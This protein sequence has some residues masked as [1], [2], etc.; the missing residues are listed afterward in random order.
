MLTGKGNHSGPH[1][2]QLG[3]TTFEQ[4]IDATVP[5]PERRK[6]ACRLQP[7]LLFTSKSI[8]QG[9]L[10]STPPSAPALHAV[11]ALAKLNTYAKGLA[12]SNRYGPDKGGQDCHRISRT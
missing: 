1:E 5:K 10:L 6:G 9:C 12:P 11:A 4:I 8:L 7:V 3:P 2:S